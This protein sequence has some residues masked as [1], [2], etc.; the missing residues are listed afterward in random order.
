MQRVSEATYRFRR[1]VLIALI[2]TFLAVAG[3]LVAKNG[4]DLPVLQIITTSLML[5]T[6]PIV[7]NRVIDMFNGEDNA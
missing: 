1:Q 3:D 7:L 6:G 5:S 2:L 4:S